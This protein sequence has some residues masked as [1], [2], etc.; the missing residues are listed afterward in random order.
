MRHHEAYRAI[1]QE[2]RA[3]NQQGLDRVPTVTSQEP[4]IGDTVKPA[5]CSAVVTAST[6]VHPTGSHC[7][8]TNDRVTPI[9][10]DPKPITIWAM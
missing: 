3:K 5:Y 10:P 2:E 9:L 7:S 1:R 8:T 6:C 4:T